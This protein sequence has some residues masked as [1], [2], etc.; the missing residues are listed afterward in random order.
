MK[1]T[2]LA[3]GLAMLGAGSIFAQAA[4][5][6]VSPDRN[7]AFFNASNILTDAAFYDHAGK[8]V[9]LYYHTPW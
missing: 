5:G 1:T 9:V 6:T 2:F 3:A 7:Y 4:V 8:I